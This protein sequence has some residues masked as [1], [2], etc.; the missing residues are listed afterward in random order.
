MPRNED[1]RK[2]ALLDDAARHMTADGMTDA[3]TAQ[4]FIDAFYQHVPAPEILDQT[5]RQRAFTAAG[6]WRFAATRMPG[7]PAIEVVD[8]EAGRSIIHIVNDDMRFLVDSTAASLAA[9]GLM[10]DLVIHP[11][12]TVERD[13]EGRLRSFS[14]SA[15]TSPRESWMQIVLASKIE[16]DRKEAVIAQ[17]MATLADV[18]AVVEDWPVM[19]TQ[20]LDLAQTIRA[21]PRTPSDSNPV[22]DADFLGWLDSGNFLYLGTRE[23]TFDGAQLDVVPGHGRGMLR[24][25]SVLVFDGL[26]AIA[27]NS[28][29]VQAFLRAPQLTM[30]SKSTRRSPVHR[31]LPMDTIIVKIFDEHREVIGL[32]LLIGLFT[33]E[34]LTRLPLEIPMLRQKIARCAE[35]S[36]FAADSRDGHALQHILDTFPRD[37]LFQIDETQLYE[38]AIGI[39]HLKQRP[40]LALFVLRDPFERFATCLVYLPR[41]RFNAEV[42]RRIATILEHE[43]GGQISAED[44]HFEGETLVRLHAMISLPPGQ[45]TSF[46]VPEVEQRLR[47]ALRTWA[48]R[49]REELQRVHGLQEGQARLARYA[50]AFPPAYVDQFAVEAAVSDIARIDAVLSGSPIEVSLSQPQPGQMRLRIYHA[51]TPVALSDVLPML[52]NLGVRVIN[53]IP[54]AIT[55]RDHV[56]PI[57]MQELELHP[58]SAGN[59]HATDRFEEAFRA[60]WSGVIESDGFNR[61]VLQVGLS[62]REVTILRT[63]CKLIRQTGSLFSQAYMEDTANAHPDIA[64]LLVRLFHTRANPALADADR[65]ETE[66][67]VHSQILEA[68]EHVENLDEDRILRSFL[69]LIEKTLRTNYYQRDAAGSPKSYLSIKIASREIEL[70]PQPRPLVEIFVYSPRMEGCHLRGG[71][72]ARGGIRWSDRKED[73]RTEVLGLMKAQMVKNA[74]IVPIGSKGGFVVKRM[75]DGPRD[76]QMEEVIACYKTLMFGMLDITDDIVGDRVVPPPDVVRHDPDDTY[77]VVAADK[78]TAT[79]SDIANG[80]AIDYGFWLGDAFASGGSIGYDHKV[81]GITAKGAWEAVKRHFREIGTDIQTTDF[82]CVGVGDMA[83]DVFGNGM[84]LSRHTRLIAAFNHMHIFIDPTPDPER[85]WQERVRMFHLPRS[86]W[87]DYDASVLSAGGGVYDRKAKAITLSSEACTRLGL[88]HVPIAPGALIQHLLQQDVDLLWFGGIGTYVKASTEAQADAG[89]RANDA[90]RINATQLRAKVIGEGANLAITQRARIEYA[91]RGGRLNTDAIDNSAGVDT[92]DHE[93]NIKI[94]VGD[95]IKAGHIAQADRAAFLASLVLDVEHHVL[96]D[97]Y[98]Q[99]FA[100]SLTEAQAAAQL[101]SHAGFM[102]ALERRGR[103]DRAVE[104]LP[105]DEALAQRAAARRGLTRP[106]IA[107]LLAYA[108]NNLSDELV[109]THLPDLPELRTELLD[110]FPERLRLLAPDTIARHRLHRE[111]IATIIANALVNR[112]GPSFVHDMQS[113]TGRDADS[114]ARAFLIVRDVFG[115]PALWQAIE[116]LDNQVPSATQ[117]RLCLA[118]TAIVEQAVRWFLLSGLPLTPAR[119]VNAFKPGIDLLAETLPSLLP[120]RERGINESRIEAHI[121][122]GAPAALAERI[123]IL[124][125][126]STAM[127]IVQISEHLVRDITDVARTYFAAGVDYGLLLVRRQARALQATTHWQRLAADALTDDSYVQQRELTQRLVSS[128]AASKEALASTALSEVLMDIGRTSPPDLAMLT[129]A[130]RRIRTAI[131]LVAG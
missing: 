69:L 23:Y 8:D 87:R 42:S 62:A 125:T 19:R 28:P 1:A 94:A 83:G 6:M 65:T 66:A 24:D 55:P 84:M 72:V 27:R 89:D 50:Q 106:E 122:A 4:R 121:A 105:D 96:R 46:S 85:S 118:I 16:P 126:L 63:Y 34:S 45:D 98:L 127:D 12:L 77:L 111:I 54:F 124:N 11:V 64:G 110:Y 31:P 2:Q 22:E 36:G 67:T 115:L 114:V 82:S 90:L 30:V 33:T 100:L 41:D 73:F 95:A 48:D 20:A 97:N 18:R 17:L 131:G 52:E 43:I 119:G 70:L 40:A 81:M 38:T 44:T 32:R 5:P 79:F 60:V 108:K 113:R 61:L 7:Y 103:L 14:V 92:S 15:A 74:V 102:R 109:E 39:L 78:G 47:D 13:G 75:P 68:L 99:T 53:E 29:D 101:D 3:I 123:V 128:S 56:G 26:R 88:P 86:S 130:T 25:D 58:K 129:V 93:V 35:R 80:V 21:M 71:K 9:L 10:V 76:V 51:D 112:L 59:E 37:E 120:D 57:W 49:L 107:V 104:F 116:A 117:T 91:L